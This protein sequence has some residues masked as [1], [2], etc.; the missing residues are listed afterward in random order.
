MVL[1]ERQNSTHQ[2]GSVP[3]V[4]LHVWMF[5]LRCI[6]PGLQKKDFYEVLGVSRDASQE[7]IKKAYYQVKDLFIFKLIGEIV[8]WAWLWL[9]VVGEEISSR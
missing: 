4:T 6:A 3:R 5:L 7:E 1:S 2:V 8:T 9:T